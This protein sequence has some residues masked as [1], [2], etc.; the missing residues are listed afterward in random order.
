[1][2]IDI[3]SDTICPWCFVGKRRLER[4]LALRTALAPDIT[5]W[6]FQL[7]PDMPANG[8]DRKSYLEAKFGG[9][10]GAERIYARIRDAGRSEGIEFAFD[11]VERT[12]NTIDSHRLIHW[13]GAAGCQNDVVEG[14]FRA[15][16]LEGRDIGDAAVLVD[17]ARAA[18]MD[19]D[20][21]ALRLASE[22]D[23]DLVMQRNRSAVEIGVSGVPCFI[24]DREQAISGAQDASVFLQVFDAVAGG[25]SET[26][27][28]GGAMPT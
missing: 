21:V 18:G 4:A 16:F 11:A 23:R 22:R 24:I 25:A 19:A 1:M 17:V 28:G 27:T 2:R 26:R 13:A 12:P 6:P 7:N 14:L 20:D 9:P 8:R 15:Y 10:A 5:W 3:V